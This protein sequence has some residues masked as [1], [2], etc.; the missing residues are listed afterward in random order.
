M[1]P[2]TFC[3][4]GLIALKA[5]RKSDMCLVIGEYVSIKTGMQVRSTFMGVFMYLWESDSLV[6]GKC[7]QLGL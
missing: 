3:V 1:C 2:V 5:I 6:A 4:E 7:K